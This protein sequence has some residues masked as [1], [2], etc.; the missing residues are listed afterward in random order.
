[1][2]R[3]GREISLEV[4]KLTVDLHQS[5]HRLCE[6]NKLLNISYMTIANTNIYFKKY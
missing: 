6:K 2:R 1:M 4:R 3:K 5:G